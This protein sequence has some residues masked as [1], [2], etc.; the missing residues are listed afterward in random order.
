[1]MLFTCSLL[2]E[3]SQRAYLPGIICPNVVGVV[4]RNYESLASCLHRA[5]IRDGDVYDS[6]VHTHS[7]VGSMLQSKGCKF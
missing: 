6:D 5:L 3:H 2:S 4:S 1:M 7:N